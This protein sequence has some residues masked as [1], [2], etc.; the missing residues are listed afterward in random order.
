MLFDST[1]NLLFFDTATMM[2][3]NVSDAIRTAPYQFNCTFPSIHYFS[4]DFTRWGNWVVY[5]AG[6]GVFAYNLSTHA[7]QPVLLN[8]RESPF[9]T[10]RYPVVLPDG[11]LFV[12]G[13]TSAS[14]ATGADGPSIA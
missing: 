5:V 12:T 10:Y 13:L 2:L 11:T 1:T 3:T 8:T 9:I 14:G 4:Q 6:D 7:I